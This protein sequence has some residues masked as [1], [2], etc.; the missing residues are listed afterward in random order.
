MLSV[1]KPNAEAY[2]SYL[3]LNYSRYY[4][5]RT[6]PNNDLLVKNGF[7]SS[8]QKFVAFCLCVKASLRAKPFI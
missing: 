7:R 8:V 3:N 6:G 4:N 2:D 1:E 5:S